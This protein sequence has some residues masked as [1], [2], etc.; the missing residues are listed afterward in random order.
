M[1]LLS[2][3]CLIDMVTL[4][5]IGF[6]IFSKLWDI[7]FGTLLKLNSKETVELDNKMA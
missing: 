6:G 3:S 5:S 1:L 7:P 4:S 2:G